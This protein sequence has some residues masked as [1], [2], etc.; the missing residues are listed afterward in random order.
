M[1]ASLTYIGGEDGASWR[2]DTESGHHLIVDGSP[3]IGGK[4]LGARP[5][6]FVLLGL[7]GCSA[8]DVLEILRK[9]RKTVKD[10]TI[11][12]KAQRAETVPKVFTH[13]HLHY[14]VYGTD[15]LETTV[16]RA[17][18]LSREK[19]CSVARMLAHTAEITTSYEII[20]R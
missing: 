15:L 2:A 11:Q 10:C 9:G 8:M 4:N 6:E 16:D 12:L 5:M 20:D 17:V 7:G 19:Y 13:I 14:Q 3:N 18:R 1:E